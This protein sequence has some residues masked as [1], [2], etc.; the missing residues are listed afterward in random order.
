[1]SLPKEQRNWIP[2]QCNAASL[3]LYQL[4]FTVFTIQ[5]QIGFSRYL[6]R[7]HLPTS[8]CLQND[9]HRRTQSPRNNI[10][11]LRPTLSLHDA[12]LQAPLPE[13]AP[14]TILQPLYPIPPPLLP[15]NNM[16][17]EDDD[18]DQIIPLTPP[19]IPLT[20]PLAIATPPPVLPPTLLPPMPPAQTPLIP[21]PVE[22]PRIRPRRIAKPSLA[23]REAA[24]TTA[25]QQSLKKPKHVAKFAITNSPE[26]ITTPSEPLTYEE[27]LASPERDLWIN[28][29]HEELDSLARHKTW[30][31]VPCPQYRNVIGTKWVFKSKDSIPRRFKARLVAQGYSQIPSI[32]YNETF[33]PVVKSTS[34]HTLFA[35]AVQEELYIY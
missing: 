34:V 25:I 31:L 16:D 18:D 4:R 32:N 29:I 14:Q 5:L 22:D 35:I 15:S 23:A 10:A 6:Q 2:A 13:P 33:A 19:P 20:E 28:A 12:Y 26:A 1:M 9:D 17:S 11:P 27:A 21:E 3:V 24:E 30:Q 7:K 8:S